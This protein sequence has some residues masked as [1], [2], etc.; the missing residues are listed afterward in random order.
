MAGLQSLENRRSPAVSQPDAPVGLPRLLDGSPLVGPTALREHIVRYGRLPSFDRRPVIWPRADRA[1]GSFGSSR[2]GRGELPHG[3]QAGRC[4]R[5]T[6][7]GHRRWERHR[8]RTGQLEGQGPPGEISTP[9][10]GRRCRCRACC[11]RR[12]GDHRVPPCCPRACRAGDTRAPQ[13]RDRPCPAAS[14]QCR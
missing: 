5:P 14:C 6:R 11:W 9:C 13:G 12:R 10:P 1:R 7:P 4:G 8:R 2:S 3:P